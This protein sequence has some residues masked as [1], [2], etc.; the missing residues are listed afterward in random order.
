MRTNGKTPRCPT[1]ANPRKSAANAFLLGALRI[2][3][4]RSPKFHSHFPSYLIY[5]KNEL[6]PFSFLFEGENVLTKEEAVNRLRNNL[7]Y[8]S[9]T[10]GV[11]K[12]GLFGSYAKGVQREDS[13]VDLLIEFERPIGLK[14]VALANHLEALLGKNIDILTPVGIKKIRIKKVSGDIEK[15]IVY[16]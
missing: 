5:S 10:Y 11:K 9:L 8:L 13:D 12:I 3:K 4:Q 1:R 2:D 16:V 6:W 14:F 7:P 15:G